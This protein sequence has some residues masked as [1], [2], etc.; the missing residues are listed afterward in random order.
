[1]S[2]MV[3]ICG[4]TR[5]EDAVAAVELGADFIGLN[6]HAA[7]PR[8]LTL[9][10]A[11]RVRDAIGGGALAVGVFVQP[12]RRQV[13]EIRRM[14][15]L[16]MLQFAAGADDETLARWPVPVIHAC[17]VMPGAPI[18]RPSPPNY[19]LLDSADPNRHGAR[20]HITLNA[21]D[22]L[23]L[24]RTFIAGGLTAENVAAVAA[25]GPYGVDVASGVES[26][27]GIKDPDKLRC[28][29]RN[30]KSAR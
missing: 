12:E 26:A 2:L 8:C 25:L 5:P 18:A 22:A 10:Q 16:D 30:A 27:L 20:M 14:L 6:F 29:I 11:R 23:D 3:K 13:E 4:V 17:T 9:D 1:M 24:S 15:A 7:S 28:F 19:L 21:L